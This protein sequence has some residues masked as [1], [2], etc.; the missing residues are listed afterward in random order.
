MQPESNGTA[1]RVPSSHEIIRG[2]KDDYLQT[3]C[4]ADMMALSCEEG[5][6]EPK[7]RHKA[8]KADVE[9]AGG[10]KWPGKHKWLGGQRLSRGHRD[11]EVAKC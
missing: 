10:V 2:Q 11:Q 3:E 7:R 8:K 9:E 1:R 4:L 5:A 6:E